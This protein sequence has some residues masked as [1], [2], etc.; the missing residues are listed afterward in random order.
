MLFESWAT[1]PI[2]ANPQI[3][4]E[5]NTASS[6]AFYQFVKRPNQPSLQQSCFSLCTCLLSAL[7]PWRAFQTMLMKRALISTMLKD[8]LTELF[9]ENKH[10]QSHKLLDCNL[11][12]QWSRWISG[13]NC[14]SSHVVQ[15]KCFL[16]YVRVLSNCLSFYQHLC[17]N[18]LC[19]SFSLVL[20]VSESHRGNVQKLAMHLCVMDK[21]LFVVAS[22]QLLMA[23]LCRRK[24]KSKCMLICIPVGYKV[25]RA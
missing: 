17:C 5:R 7:F 12:I 22:V 16:E 3:E 18:L 10:H 1:S 24:G 9:G 4:Q 21:K 6:L 19:L 14:P 20:S 2:P 25:T 8:S 11:F 15:T 13:C 23:F